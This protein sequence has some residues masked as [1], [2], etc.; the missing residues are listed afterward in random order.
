[1]GQLGPF[2]DRPGLGQHPGGGTWRQPVGG[3]QVRPSRRRPGGVG[4]VAVVD[5]GDQPG[6]RGVEPGLGGQRLVEPVLQAGVVERPDGGGGEVVKAGVHR[7]QR[8]PEPVRRQR[9]AG[10][11][12]CGAAD[13]HTPTVEPRT[14]IF[15]HQFDP[16][17]CVCGRSV[18]RNSG[19]GTVDGY[20]R[21][22]SADFGRPR[23]QVD[24][25]SFENLPAHP[26][27]DPLTQ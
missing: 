9:P 17:Y 22:P 6:D 23:P 8:L 13:R 26:A 4:Q 1:M 14:D 20:G 16:V 25:L 18:V 12:C 19:S 5:L 21:F 15:E 3:D 2:G 10:V 24:L 7:G 27:V 11:G